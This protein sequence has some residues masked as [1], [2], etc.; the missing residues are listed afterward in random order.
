M[1]PPTAASTC[2][3]YAAIRAWLERVRAEPGFVPLRRL[4]ADGRIR[5]SGS[6]LHSHDAIGSTHAP[7]YNSGL[8]GS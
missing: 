2:R 5:R 6:A 8:P 7:G 3:R 1:W 4:I